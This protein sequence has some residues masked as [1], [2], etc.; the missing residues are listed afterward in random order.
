MPWIK[1]NLRGSVVFAR[2]R[3]DGALDIGADGR[4]D[5]KYK[6]G[7]GAK[8][9]RAAERNLAPADDATPIE[10]PKPPPTHVHSAEAIIIYTDGG[11]A[12]NP[13][14]MGIGVV[15]KR[16]PEG[17][18]R[19]EIGEFLGVGTNNIAELTAIERALD[20][21]APA[22][23]DHP[24]LLHA[25]SS[26][27]LGVVSGEMKAKKNVELVERIREKARAFP[28]LRFVKVRG[29]A[30]VAENERCDALVG[31]AIAAGQRRA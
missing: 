24:I 27:A 8:I 28:H 31:A 15:I 9:Y 20:A 18:A 21:L 17:R 16:G 30:G 3:P 23:R 19:Q 11:A 25:D 29:H 1:R 26:Y 22:D 12:P 4:V 10:D 7:D 6:L 2:A 13:G 5:V 14:P